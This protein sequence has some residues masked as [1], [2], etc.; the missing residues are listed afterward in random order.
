MRRVLLIAALLAA[1][2]TGCGGGTGGGPTTLT[3]WARSDESSFIRGVVNGFNRSH[4]DIRVKLTLIPTKNFVQ[5]FG[6]AVAG[7]TGP[8]LAS[9]D[10]VYLPFFAHVGVLSD[11]TERAKALPYVKQFDSAHMGNARFQG[12]LYALPFS[13][14]ASVLFYNTELFKAAG[15][16]PND[17]PRTWADIEKDARKVTHSGKHRYGY[18]FSGACGGCAVFTFLPLVWASGGKILAGPLT[19]QRPTLTGNKQLRAALAFYHRMWTEH[20]VPQQAPNDD[21]SSQFTPF[22][23]GNVAMF[24][25]GAFGVSTFRQDAPHLKWDVTPIPGR[26][27]GS[28]SFAGGDEIAIGK[29]SSHQDQAW[30]FIKWATSASVQDKYF[31][32]QGVIP[33]RRDVAQRTYATKGPAFK[34]LTHA[35]FAG[36]VVK[37][38]QENALINNSTGPW[39]T[40]LERAWFG[41][42]IRPAIQEAQSVMEN[43]LS[44]G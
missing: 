29:T 10:L 6:L 39:T 9:I 5:K 23:S 37:S 24:S 40:M 19:D 44:R 42:R 21:G 11:L 27:G 16:D 8:D 43:V 25:T 14:D 15:L 12:R 18:Y 1:V 34:T 28:S 31:G 35:L 13:G 36:K 20:L 30:E 4:H 26:H 22:E 32:R 41:G 3:L 17:P 38:V 33:I 2:T 7:G